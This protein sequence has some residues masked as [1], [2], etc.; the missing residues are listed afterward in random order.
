MLRPLCP[1]TPFE[2]GLFKTVS[3]HTWGSKVV[4]FIFRPSHCL[5]EN[6]KSHLTV[7]CKCTDEL[8]QIFSLWQDEQPELF[9]QL[10]LFLIA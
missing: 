8:G 1:L 7:Y 10:R 9:E 5:S 3:T 2:N 4:Q 6:S